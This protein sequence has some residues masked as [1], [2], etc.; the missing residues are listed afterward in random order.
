[1]S[2]TTVQDGNVKLY[3]FIDEK[4]CERVT[5]AA[6]L[7]SSMAPDWN[8]Q[9]IWLLDWKIDA[10][11]VTL[12]YQ[13]TNSAYAAVLDCKLPVEQSRAKLMPPNRS[14]NWEWSEYGAE[15]RNRKTGDRFKPV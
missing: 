10:D 1:M 7:P 2:T 8:G 15:W 13:L 12:T 9:T 5:T 6:V 3:S 11:A 4:T 14:K